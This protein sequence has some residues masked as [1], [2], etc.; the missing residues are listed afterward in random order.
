MLAE[1]ELAARLKEE[2]A[3]EMCGSSLYQTEPWGFQSEDR[4]LNKALGFAS[5][6]D[7]IRM[8]EICK[9]TEIS[10]G[11]EESEPKYDDKGDRIYSS[12]IIDIDI[13]LMGDEVVDMPNLQIP[14][15]RLHEREFALEPLCEIAAEAVH[16][17]IGRSIKEI[18]TDLKERQIATVQEIY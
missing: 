10:L 15:P 9:E 6:I 5:S 16:P 12:R 11:R 2:G 18:L 3:G 7:P 17:V 1:K 8:L 13:L 14:H 4:F